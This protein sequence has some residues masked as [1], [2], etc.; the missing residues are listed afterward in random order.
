MLA[1]VIVFITELNQYRIWDHRFGSKYL[2]RLKIKN[3]LMDLKEKLKN[4]NPLNICE[5][6]VRSLY[7]S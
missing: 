1:G 3:P 7:L 4:G 5:E 2:L 6:F